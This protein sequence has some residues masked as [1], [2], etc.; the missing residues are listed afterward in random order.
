MEKLSTTYPGQWWEKWVILFRSIGEEIYNFL[1]LTWRKKGY[2]IFAVFVLLF[3]KIFLWSTIYGILWWNISN[4]DIKSSSAILISMV[5][6]S[7]LLWIFSLQNRRWKKEGKPLYYRP[8][9]Y[10]SAMITFLGISI[11]LLGVVRTWNHNFTSEGKPIMYTTSS[12]IGGMIKSNNPGVD[13]V[14]GKPKVAITPSVAQQ[15]IL[16]KLKESAEVPFDSIKEFIDPNGFP[17]IW[18]YRNQKSGEYHFYR[19]PGI[20]FDGYELIPVTREAIDSYRSIQSTL[21]IVNDKLSSARSEN[22]NLISQRDSLQAQVQ[23]SVN[24]KALW[25][26]TEEDLKKRLQEVTNNYNNIR[27][28]KNELEGKLK[29]AMEKAI[30]EEKLKD[31]AINKSNT[32]T[33]TSGGIVVSA[34]GGT[35]TGISDAKKYCD[36]PLLNSIVVNFKEALDGCVKS[37]ADYYI[38]QALQE[39]LPE[40]YGLMSKLVNSSCFQNDYYIQKQLDKLRDQERPFTWGRR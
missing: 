18:Y 21:K 35:G 17:K 7:T 32:P 34:T 23:N 3:A 27:D 15:E 30:T 10:V 26:V 28:E 24:E 13:E 36:D 33:L 37:R 39:H 22:E 9:C 29:V 6:T 19:R 8:F 20:S 38:R 5:C 1:A 4:W 40:A 14:T 2:I 31:I 16:D 25:K 12:P 11:S